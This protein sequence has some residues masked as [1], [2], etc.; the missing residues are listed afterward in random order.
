MKRVGIG[1]DGM[2]SDVSLLDLTEEHLN[3]I[4][5]REILPPELIWSLKE[6]RDE[7]LTC[8]GL[9]FDE[10][11]FSDIY[12][13]IINFSKDKK[14][15]LDA[16]IG[17]NCALEVVTAANLLCDD[18]VQINKTKIDY[19][20]FWSPKTMKRVPERIPEGFLRHAQKVE[21]SE[22][23]SLIIPFKG[24]R[25]ILSFGGN[26]PIRILSNEL[27]SYLRS[28]V[29]NYVKEK[30]PNLLIIVGTAVAWSS[31][32]KNDF[33]LLEEIIRDCKRV[34]TLVL[35][36]LGGLGT[37]SHEF[38][39]SYFKVLSKADILSM[40]ES[41]LMIYYREWTEKEPL[42]TSAKDLS[43]MVREVIKEGQGFLVHTPGFQFS[44]GL[45]GPICQSLEFAGKAASYRASHREFPSASQVM[46]SNFPISITGVSEIKGLPNDFTGV[47][48]YSVTVKNT[49]GLGDTWTCA[50]GLHYTGAIPFKKEV[51]I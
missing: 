25:S 7:E 42:T 21:N 28:E 26:P 22:A 12:K 3:E 46:N 36:D 20:G 48:G 24:R 44:Y 38:L 40:N 10:N 37:W 51:I 17:A 9:G 31:A 8:E 41:E 35:C 16:H 5:D 50:F 27:R 32:Q 11:E 23:I 34:Q 2:C 13:N 15:R 6:D 47:P 39:H 1:L 19:L 30:K 33:E 49:V 29:I 18:S 4:L 14:I 45:E 43:S